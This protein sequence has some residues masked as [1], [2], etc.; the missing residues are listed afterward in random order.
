M[1]FQTE[2]SFPR[3]RLK[4]PGNWS[5]WLAYFCVTSCHLVTWIWVKLGHTSLLCKL[6]IFCCCCKTVYNEYNYIDWIS[7]FSSR[8][9]FIYLMNWRKRVVQFLDTYRSFHNLAKSRAVSIVWNFLLLIPTQQ[10]PNIEMSHQHCFYVLCYWLVN[11][12]S[13]WG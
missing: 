13:G 4:L 10:A 5:P 1:C 7:K 12:T 3:P 11:L 8:I 9:I 2:Y 6:L